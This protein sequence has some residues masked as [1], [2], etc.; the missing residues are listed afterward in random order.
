MRPTSEAPGNS[1]P[2]C[3]DN[4]E[5][6]AVA[7]A[8]VF[9]ILFALSFSHLVNDTLQSLIPAI[10]PILKTELRLDYSHIGLI[11]L[12]NQLTASLLQPFVG[13]FTDKHPQPFSLALGM[14]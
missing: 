9:G 11:T 10:Y 6:D 5:P 14:A 7:A 12:T 4:A 3:V 1:P 8:P 2:A 13:A